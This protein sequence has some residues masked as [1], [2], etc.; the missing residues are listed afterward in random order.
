MAAQGSGGD[1]GDGEE[2]QEEMRRFREIYGNMIP[3][4][5]VDTKIGPVRFDL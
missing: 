4:K 1:E 2:D 3:E 5:I